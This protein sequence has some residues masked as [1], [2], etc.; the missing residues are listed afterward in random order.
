MNKYVQKILSE[1]L[2]L[3]GPEFEIEQSHWSLGPKPNDDQRPRVV[4]VKFLHYTAREK[5]LAAVKKSKGFEWEEC[6]ISIFE[7]MSREREQ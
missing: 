5:V 7:D 3:T 4:L 1:G 6:K 2:G